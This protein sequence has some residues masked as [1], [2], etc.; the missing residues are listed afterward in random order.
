MARKEIKNLQDLVDRHRYG[1]GEPIEVLAR[2]GGV[3]VPTLRKVF[4]ELGCLD[5]SGRVIRPKPRKTRKGS[6][7]L[8]SKGEI[9]RGV[10]PRKEIPGLHDL[11]KRFKNGETLTTLS[12]EAGVSHTILKRRLIEEGF[13]NPGVSLYR[14]KAE[15]DFARV[16]TDR[17]LELASEGP[18]VVSAILKTLHS[19]GFEHLREYHISHT[20]R[21]AGITPARKPR[22]KR[23]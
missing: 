18:A 16:P 20:I 14:Q 17:I 15:N 3:S 19:E 1:C 7:M 12:R 9:I 5:L 13:I 22:I 6:S 2:D 8:N 21:R 11:G 10:R 23:G 4:G